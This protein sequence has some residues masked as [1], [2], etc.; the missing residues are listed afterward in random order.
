MNY[1]SFDVEHIESLGLSLTQVNKQLERY[2]SPPARVYIKASATIGNG[3]V[4]LLDSD[5]KGLIN[6]YEEQKMLLSVVKFTPASGAASRMFKMLHEFLSEYNPQKESINSY[7]NKNKIKNDF[8]IT[9]PYWRDSLVKCIEKL[10]S[11]KKQS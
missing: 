10:N 6:Y 8:N 9:I 7:I 4:K 5:T 3:I 11:N 1:S 2:K